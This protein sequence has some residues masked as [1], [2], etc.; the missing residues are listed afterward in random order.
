MV[1][2]SRLCVLQSEVHEADE[3]VTFN[4]AKLNLK[5]PTEAGVSIANKLTIQVHI[6]Q[7]ESARPSVKFLKQGALTDD[8][9]SV[10]SAALK[11]A[12]K[13]TSLADA[14][15]AAAPSLPVSLR[16]TVIG[17][18]HHQGLLTVFLHSHLQWLLLPCDM[19]SWRSVQSLS[20]LHVVRR[21]AI[22]RLLS[23]FTSTSLCCLAHAPTHSPAF[24]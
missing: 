13:V 8:E 24:C 6:P 22:C 3:L 21:T 12:N 11:A 1:I 2:V 4:V 14:T 15:Q 17:L 16:H 23:C 18:A 20:A 9:L 19:T 10:F 7:Q 5:Q